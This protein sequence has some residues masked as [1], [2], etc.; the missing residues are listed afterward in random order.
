MRDHFLPLPATPRRW[1]ELKDVLHA[2]P[3]APVGQHRTFGVWH[4][5]IAWNSG[6]R[7]FTWPSNHQ[8][9]LPKPKTKNS[10]AR[11]ASCF[12][13]W[14]ACKAVLNFSYLLM[15][16]SHLLDFSVLWQYMAVH[17][18][19]SEMA[20]LA[21]SPWASHQWVFSSVLSRSRAWPGDIRGLMNHPQ[22]FGHV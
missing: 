6:S 21:F 13:L 5:M 9:W 16:A 15:N 1:T 8:S 19:M 17:F 7:S 12:M 22:T 10:M 18:D 14:S 2:F 20:A 11:M 3:P 4:G